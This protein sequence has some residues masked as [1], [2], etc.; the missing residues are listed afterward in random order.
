MRTMCTATDSVQRWR[1]DAGCA[2]LADPRGKDVGPAR[3]HIVYISRGA[4]GAFTARLTC[5]N[6]TLQTSARVHAE[7]T[8]RPRV[9]TRPRHR[10]ASLAHLFSLSLALEPLFHECM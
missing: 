2:F 9:E 1:D 4:R 8:D 6:R 5:G 3:R 10:R 7:R